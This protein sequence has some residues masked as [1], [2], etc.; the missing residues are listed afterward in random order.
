[1]E[2]NKNKQTVHMMCVRERDLVSYRNMIRIS[3]I[4]IIE[5]ISPANISSVFA[6]HPSFQFIIGTVLV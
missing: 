2:Q 5:A 6:V 4:Q 3:S 1:M